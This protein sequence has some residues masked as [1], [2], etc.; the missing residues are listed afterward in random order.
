MGDRRHKGKPV[1]RQKR[2]KKAPG[3]IRAN[4]H[5]KPRRQRDR[6]NDY[7]R[8]TDKEIPTDE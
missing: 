1:R 5:F 4:D 2:L 3:H 6:K 7:H 8:P